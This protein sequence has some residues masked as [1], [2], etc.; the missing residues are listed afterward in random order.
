MGSLIVWLVFMGLAVALLAGRAAGRLTATAFAVLAIALVA[1]DLFK[2][3]MGA[4]PAITT[5]QAQQPS[6]P[7]LRY[8]QD[9][10]PNRFV[11]IQRPLG[12][13][14]LVPNAGMRWE[15]LDARGWDPPVEERYDTLWRQ[16]VLD[17]GPTDVPTT[18]ARLTAAALP[19]FRLLS[20]TD[21]VQDPDDP[22]VEDPELPV[23]YDARDLRA[24][25][26]P[27]PLPRAGVV[28]SQVVVPGEQDQ[29]DAVLDPDFDGRST[30]VTPTPLPGL[31]DG[32][33][34]GP[35]GNA[36]VTVYEPERVVVEAT[37]RRPAELVLTDLH[38][39]GWKVTLDGEPADMH[40]VNYLLRGASLPTG[41]HRVEFRYEPTSYRI[42]WIVSLVAL[43]AL[44]GTVAY[45]LRR[46]RG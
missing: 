46:R 22:P 30:L 35:A 41:S 31:R 38:Y 23:S 1:A 36:H 15:L 39:P 34:S 10:R 42:G 26:T 16:A 43:L 29:L 3:G 28:D 7:G 24:Y 21:I 5:E 12:P 6:T 44:L 45:G 2:A 19:A 9:R 14:P 33:G 25:A 40:R 13:S 4:T 27:R 20:V 8:L 37:A 11:G 17:G 32:T 18:D